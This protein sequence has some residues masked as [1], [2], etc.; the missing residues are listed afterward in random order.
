MEKTMVKWVYNFTEGSSEDKALLGGKGANLAEMSHLGLP[1]PRG[2]TITTEAC[3]NYLNH[4]QHLPAELL[5]QLAD[6]VA[7][8]SAATGKQFGDLDQPLL[9]SVRSGSKFS[10]P[11]MMDTILNLG[12]NDQTVESL[13]RNSNNPRFAYDCY[14][15]LIQMFGDVVCGIDASLFERVL[16]EIK[17]NHGLTYDFELSAEQLQEL[18]QRYKKIFLKETG[19]N[20]PQDPKEQLLQAVQAVFKSWNN[21]RAK[22]YRRLHQIPDDLGTAV[23]IQEMVFG[24]L[25]NDSGTGVVF[26]RDPANGKKGIYGEYLMNAQGEDVVAGIRTPTSIKELKDQQPGIFQELESIC[27]KLE[28][29]Y[30]DMQ[31]IEFTI[32]HQKL[33]ILQTRTGKRTPTAGIQ[34]AMDLFYEGKIAQEEVE[35]RISYSDI[36][37]VLHPSFSPEVLAKAE[38]LFSGLAASPGAAVGR[39]YFDAKQAKE[40]HDAGETVI[41][42]RE[43]TS[44]EDIAGIAASSA[45]V[46]CRGGM[47]SHAAVVARGMGI[48]AVVG[49][50]ELQIDSRKRCLRIGEQVIREGEVLSVDGGKGQVYAGEL[51]LA[52]GNQVS[53]FY[54][55]LQLISQNAPLEI[56]GNGETPMDIKQA[57]DFQA[58]GIGLV[59]TEHMFFEQERLT[60]F[61]KMI[62]APDE[63]QRQKSV[64]A[65]KEIQKKDFVQI[66]QLTQDKPATIRLLD[67]P[68]HEFLPKTDG[69]CWAVAEKVGL[70]YDQVKNQVESLAE[71]NPMLGFRGVRLGLVYPEIYQMQAEAITEAAIEVTRDSGKAVPIEIMIPFIS[72]VAEF[73]QMR[74]EIEPKIKKVMTQEK[75]E[76]PYLIGTMIEIPRACFVAEELAMY[77]DFFSFGTNDLT[78]MAYGLSRDDS[79]RII[80]EYLNQGL[81]S[82]DPFQVLDIEGVGQLM[83]LAVEGGRRSNPRLKVGVCGEAGAHPESLQFIK[84]LGVDYVSCSPYRIPLAKLAVVK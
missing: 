75:M 43:E 13:A 65:L 23:N 21:E 41:L 31:D 44:P 39:I 24:N 63:A 2:F 35:S 53:A 37:Y 59:R 60:L 81:F 11:G 28:A 76:L 33:F 69:E 80:Q 84:K 52:Q 25:G 26:T 8:L 17:T 6:A 64:A 38:V 36:D 77:A 51:P 56:R 66:Y 16:T 42:V 19:M 78:Q 20:F 61:R 27:N 57:F 73:T 82:F 71:F 68:L 46:T 14:R 47:T 58:S 9:V 74:R 55:F 45:V 1:V 54:D 50:N 34:I 4:E 15:R 30:R 3:M 48:S 29:H 49:C 72:E 7:E 10:M 5:T 62:L 40:H 18:I 12:M 79:P 22:T 83:K 32:E 67:P 70:T